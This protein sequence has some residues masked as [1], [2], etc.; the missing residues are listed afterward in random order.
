MTCRQCGTSNAEAA[1]FCVE[2]GGKLEAGCPGCGAA[3]TGG[4]FC[5]ECGTPLSGAAPVA[6]DPAPVPPPRAEPVA[7]RRTTSVLFADLVG[8]T[9]MSEARDPEETREFLT[10]YFQTCRTVL[11]RYGGTVEKFIGDAVM[12]VWGVPVSHED[13]AERAVRAGLDLVVAVAALGD[14]PGSVRVAV[15]VGVVTGEVAVTLGALGEGMVAGDAVNTAARVQTAAGAGEVWVDEATRG[16]TAAA[17]TFANAGVHELKGKAEPVQLYRA[18]QVVAARGGAQRVDGLAAPFTGRDREFRLVKELYHAAL[19]D[20]RARLVSVIGD[21]GLGK[22]RLV[23]EFEKYVDGITQLTRWNRGRCISYG[24]G[25]A[26][27][28][29]AEMVRGRVG[30]L[31][32]DEPAVIAE[33]LAASLEALVPDVTE[34][35]YLRP[36]LATLIGA[37]D[38]AI[39]AD[40]FPRTDLFAAWRTFLERLADGGHALVL[41]VEDLQ[42]ADDGLLDFLE[43][44][45]ETL[46][47]PLFILTMGRPE[48]QQRRPQWGTGRRATTIYLEPLNANAMGAVVDGLVHGLPDDVRSALVERA[49]GVPLYAV[50]TVRGLIDRDAVVP[51]EGRYVLADDAAARVDLSA[52]SAPASLTALIAARLDALPAGERRIVQDAS[53]LGSSFTSE[54]L[55]A[56][57]GGGDHASVLDAL[58]HKEI[59]A[60]E[61]DPR[62]PE[63]GQYRFLQ[64]LVRTVAYDTLGR[65]DRKLRHLA[66]AAF[67]AASPDSEDLPGV[68]ASHYLAARDAAPTDPDAGELAERAVSLL[69]RAGTRATGLGS[70]SEGLRYLRTA[71]DLATIAED[72]ARIAS[73]A[74]RVG[75]T[76]GELLSAMELGRLS[77]ALWTELGRP[78]QAAIAAGVVVDALVVNGAAGE[79]RELVEQV[80]PTVD[81][82][83]GGE[84]AT[85]VMLTSLASALRSLGDNE[86]AMQCYERSLQLSEALSDWQMLIRNLNSYGGTLVTFGRPTVGIALINAALDLARREQ[87][88]GGEIMPLNNLA[89]LQLYRDLP[90]ARKAAEDGLAAARRHGEHTQE[91]W[92]VCNLAFGLW[93][94]GSW[95]E[96]AALVEESGAVSATASIQSRLAVL[97]HVMALAARGEPLIE[98]EVRG[99]LDSSDLSSQYF[100]TLEQAVVAFAGNRQADA[101]DLAVRATDGYYAYGGIEDDYPLFWVPAI[102]FSLAAGRLAEARRLLAQ[103]ADTPYGLTP[104]Y[105]RAQLPRMRSLIAGA[106]GDDNGAAATDLALAIDGLRSYG[107]PYYVA[108]AQ[109]ELAEL[110]TRTGRAAEARA[111][112]EAAHTAFTALGAVPWA[113]RAAATA[114][115][116]SV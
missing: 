42:W 5:P 114:S 105:L 111:H 62:S 78:D 74:A 88:I 77:Q 66:A 113:E 75:Y 65:R 36:R 41:V 33:R 97:P 72:R 14:E 70:T 73:A 40:G 71:L 99:M 32:G 81:G 86:P 13:D 59:F 112:A 94:D 27:W 53:V 29:F 102:E 21:A 34:R 4:R 2:C 91:G 19:D 90:A 115:L 20:G 6:A 93:F 11:E 60:I 64:G 49:E 37:P 51:R 23:W 22:T 98:P 52:L 87:V 7:E 67:Y 12:A 18:D 3:I 8:F 84:K 108:R 43:H 28:A 58:V 95:G 61:V 39:P 26:F 79:A 69:E 80:L 16:L 1:K 106:E 15:R 100:A 63:R 9:S 38:A 83:P 110:L 89:A 25:V 96:L 44:L 109:L 47:V 82:V 45:L 56:V 101:A 46:H 103:V 30:A 107:S 54:G 104:P 24:E 48:L 31:E 76:G 10:R 35:D 92:L 50:E 116:A 17:I 55:V 85:L 57:T 68:I